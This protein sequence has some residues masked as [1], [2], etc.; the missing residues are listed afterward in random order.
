MSQQPGTQQM[1]GCKFLQNNEGGEVTTATQ[2]VDIVVKKEAATHLAS[3]Y[4]GLVTDLISR[5][6]VEE[7]LRRTKAGSA[8]SQMA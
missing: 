1:A 6:Q 4:T 8:R 2:V 7:V 5:R 3:R